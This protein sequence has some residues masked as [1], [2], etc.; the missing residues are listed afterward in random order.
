MK[1]SVSAYTHMYTCIYV[2]VHACID[3]YTIDAYVHK[4]DDIITSIYMCVCVCVCVC[5]GIVQTI[6]T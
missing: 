6:V 3:A 5:P 4:H 2:Y 1:G